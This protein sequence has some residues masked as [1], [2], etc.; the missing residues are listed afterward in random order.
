MIQS[1]SQ[2]IKEQPITE[3]REL[4][5][6]LPVFKN[7]VEL[8]N[9]AL[10]HGHTMTQIKNSLG[11]DKPADIIDVQAASAVLF[12]LPTTDLNDPERLFE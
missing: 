8:I 2:P 4:P 3:K 1:Q 5:D 6:K 11:I 9:Y 10:K 12:G 7:G